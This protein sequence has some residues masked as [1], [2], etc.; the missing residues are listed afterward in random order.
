MHMFWGVLQK[1][2][3]VIWIFHRVNRNRLEEKKDIEERSVAARNKMDKKK[4]RKK[5]TKNEEARKN[6]SHERESTTK[7][8]EKRKRGE[9]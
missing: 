6:E 1:S 5:Q 9:K 3:S 8:E 2:S 4:E 7:K